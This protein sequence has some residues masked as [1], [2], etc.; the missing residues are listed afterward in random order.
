MT[1]DPKIRKVETPEESK[2]RGPKPGFKHKPKA[3]AKE[4]ELS[5]KQVENLIEGIFNALADRLGEIWKLK[6]GEKSLL[7]HSTYSVLI[8]YADKIGDSL[9]LG[10]FI[11]TLAIVIIPRLSLTKKKSVLAESPRPKPEII[12]P[13]PQNPSDQPIPPVVKNRLA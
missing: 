4:P 10:T 1:E 6:E 7:A 13:I 8:K 5:E 2:K 11:T 3:E 12:P 9:V